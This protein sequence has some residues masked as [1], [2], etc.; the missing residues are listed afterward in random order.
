LIK[1]WDG[2]HADAIGIFAHLLRYYRI[3]DVTLSAERAAI[4]S[5]IITVE[6]NIQPQKTWLITQFFQH[7]QRKRF[8]EIKECLARNASCTNIDRIVLLNET[9]LS[10]HWKQMKGAEKITQIIISQRLTYANFLQFV[11]DT[12][13]SNVFVMLANA[14][15]YFKSDS[16]LYLWKID[17]RDR[18][19]ALLR[20]DD[21]GE[22]PVL[23]GP[24]ADSQDAWIFSSNTI[25]SKKWPYELFNFPLG[26]MGCDNAFA[27]HLLRNHIVLHNPAMSFKIYH[28]HSSE[29]RDY[30]KKAFIR[31]DLF[32]NLCPTYLIDTKH[33]TVPKSKTISV[34]NQMV[35]FEV[36][37]SSLSNQITYCTMLAKQGRYQWSGEEENKYFETA[38]PVYQ[39]KQVCM[40]PTGLVYDPY[41][42][43][44]GK[45][46]EDPRFQYWENSKVDF[47]T[48]LTSVNKLIAI[49]LPDLSV[50]QHPDVYILQYLSRILRVTLE[51]PECA[52]ASML[53]PK[54]F[55]PFCSTLSCRLPNS[56]EMSSGYWANDIVGYLPGPSSLELGSEEI[57]ALRSVLGTWKESCTGSICTVVCDDTITPAFVKERLVPLL[58][59]KDPLWTV[60]IVTE[61][62]YG[63]YG[64]IVGASMCILM[65]GPQQRAKWAKLWA[66]PKS[67]CVVEMQQELAV[68]GEFQ[69]MCHIAELKSWVLLL[70]KGSLSDVQDQVIEQMEKWFR[71]SSFELLMIQ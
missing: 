51:V 54:A 4:L 69:H 25:K 23:F 59:K 53:M 10:Q 31:A 38:I 48:P 58:K 66:L 37:S 52:N 8:N 16:L 1:P 68:D 12:V 14:D 46:S 57:Y 22:E 32:V 33:E 30:D 47:F 18:C 63:S 34:C 39:W 29:V 35:P 44:K 65:G 67:C 19:L 60:R 11:Y 70:A 15:I 50:F 62:D 21:N 56:V 43:Y 36:Q 9:D 27:G 6:H 17:M 41:T 5:G 40:T 26:R 7:P 2:T 49:P 55:K 42:I 13:P 61:K 45:H 28:M 20:W 71:K 64:A 3:V 24:R